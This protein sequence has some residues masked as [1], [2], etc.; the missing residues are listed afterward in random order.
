MIV[1]NLK[2][3]YCNTFMI[4]SENLPNM[5]EK[6]A[7]PE[8]ITQF[9]R[10]CGLIWK[11]GKNGASNG[12][13]SDVLNELKNVNKVVCNGSAVK[14]ENETKQYEY[15]PHVHLL[16][17]LSSALGDEQVLIAI[18]SFMY[19]N[20]DPKVI[21]RVFLSLAIS[22][23]IGQF[24]KDV[25]MAPRPPSPPVIRVEKKYAEEYSMPSSH[26]MMGVVI[27]FSLVYFTHEKYEVRKGDHARKKKIECFQ[28]RSILR[29]CRFVFL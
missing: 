20:L 16:F 4:N 26:A 28:E 8:L 11:G 13:K 7:D 18:L 23:Y 17:H 3:Q 29:S 21:M 1:R 27:P 15:I 25:V 5:F 19:W 6:L 22:L 10:S 14:A 12:V 9:Q 24:A 2:L